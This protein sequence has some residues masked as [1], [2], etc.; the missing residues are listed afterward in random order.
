MRRSL[1][2]VLAADVAGYSRLMGADEAGTRAL[3]NSHLK[4]L[5]E[6]AIARQQGRIVKTLGDGILVEFLSV[7][8]AVQCAVAIQKGMAERNA[9]SAND[10]PMALT[11]QPGWKGSPIPAVS[12]YREQCSIRS[13]GS[14]IS[15]ST[16]SESNRSK[17]LL[18]LYEPIGSE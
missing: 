11:S 17:T 6:P 15:P 8:D 10:G 1:A 2:A 12:A 16:T 13:A 14:S 5:I 3:F 4:D 7:V 18:N 9:G